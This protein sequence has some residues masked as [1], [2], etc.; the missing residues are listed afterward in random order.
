M[1]SI[2]EAAVD[3]LFKI[4]PSKQMFFFFRT[5]HYHTLVLFGRSDH[6]IDFMTPHFKNKEIK[7]LVYFSQTHFLC[8][9]FS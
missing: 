6:M 4:N 2:I 8:I 9:F 1:P 5:Q 7:L 3:F